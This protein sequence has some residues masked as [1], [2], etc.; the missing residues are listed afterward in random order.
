MKKYQEGT[1]D[2]KELIENIASLV[3]EKKIDG[4]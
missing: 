4:I 3:N 1:D 2:K